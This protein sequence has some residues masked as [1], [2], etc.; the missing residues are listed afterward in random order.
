[1]WKYIPKECSKQ[2][3]LVAHLPTVTYNVDPGCWS[4]SNE[5]VGKPLEGTLQWITPRWHHPR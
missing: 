4:R 3:K 1:M 2:S 5:C